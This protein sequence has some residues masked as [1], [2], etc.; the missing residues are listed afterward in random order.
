MFGGVG[1]D[2]G[3]RSVIVVGAGIIGQ[4][5]ASTYVA[6][7]HGRWGLAHGPVTGRLLAEHIVTGKQS[8][9]IRPFD[10]LRGRRSV[11][12]AETLTLPL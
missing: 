7:G 11:S 8:E 12:S 10:P 6:G 1:A 5:A 3:P 2:H 9:T 4:V